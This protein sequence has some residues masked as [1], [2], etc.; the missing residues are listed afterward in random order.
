MLLLLLLLLLDTENI[1]T[2]RKNRIKNRKPTLWWMPREKQKSPCSNTRYLPYFALVPRVRSH[3]A[4]RSVAGNSDK[5]FFPGQE[6]IT[7]ALGKV[8]SHGTS[9]ENSVCF[10]KFQL[11]KDRIATTATPKTIIYIKYNKKY[12]P[13]KS[14]NTLYS[15]PP[16]TLSGNQFQKV[17]SVWYL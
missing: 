2:F 17:W 12:P 8:Y 7:L 9:G 3:V 1:D 6:N 10:T 16:P 14:S 13:T 4:S 5:R 15:P 11:K